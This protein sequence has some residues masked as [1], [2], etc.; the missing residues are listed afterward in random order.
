MLTFDLR[1]FE[2]AARDMDALADQIPFALANA[3]TSAAFRTK[4]ALVEETWPKAVEVRN[5]RFL[6]ASL[7]V[8]KAVRRDLSIAVYDDLGHA[9]LVALGHG[10]T[11]TGR[12][13]LAI[14]DSRNLG[15]RRTSKGV[16]KGLRPRAAPNSFKAPGKNGGEV[17]YQRTGTYK[18]ASKVRKDGTRRRAAVDERGLRLLYVLKPTASIKATVPFERDFEHVMAVE[19]RRLFPITMA[20][21]MKTRR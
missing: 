3:M 4:E 2:R 11:K 14:P 8:K 6:S 19:V 15:A 21:A 1:D 13:N 7:R 9:S 18:K 16:P 20:K 5:P 12:G 10:G 17:I